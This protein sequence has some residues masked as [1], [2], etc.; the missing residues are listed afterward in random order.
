MIVVARVRRRDDIV[1]S[2]V[3][4]SDKYGETKNSYLLLVE[5][6]N[7]SCRLIFL[8][9]ETLSGLRDWARGLVV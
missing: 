6:G 3:Y 7:G 4:L 5:S 8:S 1:H 2:Q 9:L